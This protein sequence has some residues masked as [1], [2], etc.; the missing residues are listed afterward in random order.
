MDPLTHALSGA[1]LARATEPTKL[2]EQALPLRIRLIAGFTAA[3]FPDID[4]ALRLVDTLTY[5]N[6]HQGPTHSLV[7]LLFWAF[8]LAHI[9]SGVTRNRY[10][11]RL[12]Y[13]P[14]CLG[15]AIHIAG[16]LITSYGLMLLAPF[17]TERFSVPLAFVIDLWF[18][19]IIILSLVMSGLFS[20][21]RSIAVFALICLGVYVIFLSSLHK[22]AKQIG[23][24]YT[25]EMALIHSKI[26]VLPQ[27]FSPYNWK[28]LVTE[29]ETYHI[30]LVN[31][32]SGSWASYLDVG[33]LSK[34]AAV[35]QPLTSAHW[36]QINR[37]GDSPADAV[38]VREAWHQPALADFRLFAVFPQ[39]ESLDYSEKKVCVWFYDYRFKFPLLP[40]SFR[41]GGC[42][43]EE[44]ADWYL[45]RQRGTFWID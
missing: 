9:F 16:D 38:L 5:L 12:F 37:F 34:M 3:A 24:T 42:R 22:Q 39:L 40:P 18:S 19:T 33:L 44:G 14:A 11:W 13:V 21:G 6:W 45:Q 28:I 10:S 31:L 20:C 27:P 7:M 8:L 29:G 41:Y 43:E 1:L 15:I 32:G 30:L 17:S 25:Q 35:Y 2:T 4:V 36:Q 26:N 23:E